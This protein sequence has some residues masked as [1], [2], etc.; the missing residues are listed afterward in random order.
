MVRKL[1]FLTSNWSS[2]N[3]TYCQMGIMPNQGWPPVV[4]SFRIQILDL[5]CAFI[6]ILDVAMHC[7]LSCK[8]LN[9]VFS[10]LKT[11]IFPMWFLKWI[12]CMLFSWS[13]KAIL[14]QNTF[15]LWSRISDRCSPC[16]DG[17]PP[18]MIFIG[19]LMGVLTSANLGY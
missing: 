11:T 10:W 19:R 17:I 14:L 2:K 13:N 6:V 15:N 7:R 18:L 3:I 9:W 4:V 8:L 1:Y 5:L 12:L 16:K